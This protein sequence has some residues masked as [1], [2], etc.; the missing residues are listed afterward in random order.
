MMS[1][2]WRAPLRGVRT[3]ATQARVPL[4]CRLFR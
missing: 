2:P 3:T 4:G 1:F